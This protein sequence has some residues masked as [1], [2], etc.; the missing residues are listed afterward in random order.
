MYTTG[1]EGNGVEAIIQATGVFPEGS[2]RDRGPIQKAAHYFA[3]LQ[4]RSQ[5]SRRLRLV[6][7]ALILHRSR[8]RFE[9]RALS[10]V[11]GHAIRSLR[12]WA[13][14]PLP[15]LSRSPRPLCSS[16]QLASAH[17]Y[18]C[19]TVGASGYHV[20][21]VALVLSAGLLAGARFDRGG[22]EPLRRFK[23]SHGPASAGMSLL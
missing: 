12:R 13:P 20:D 21:G 19:R 10:G 3:A 5:A 8:V 14:R 4:N 7:D 17:P 6:S 16:P 22:D 23:P 1:T 18:L 15:G 2:T 9:D 11:Y